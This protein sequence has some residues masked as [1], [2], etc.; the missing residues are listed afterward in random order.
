M[1]LREDQVLRSVDALGTIHDTV[2]D[3]RFLRGLTFI[4]D[5]EEDGCV[6]WDISLLDDLSDKSNEGIIVDEETSDKEE[7]RLFLVTF[8]SGNELERETEDGVISDDNALFILE[9]KEFG[10]ND[11]NKGNLSCFVDFPLEFISFEYILEG[12]R[13]L[14]IGEL[15]IFFLSRGLRILCLD[16]ERVRDFSGCLG[17]I[18]D[19]WSK[20]RES[21]GKTESRVCSENFLFLTDRDDKWDKCGFFDK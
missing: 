12:W 5:K 16:K 9:F 15:G 17:S 1:L 4:L 19:G 11:A 18:L 21:K 2:T 8:C 6:F 14:W 3:G 10:C 13:R 7:E 20:L